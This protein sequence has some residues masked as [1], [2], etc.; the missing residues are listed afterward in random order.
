MFTEIFYYIAK[1]QIID[2]TQ[3]NFC[4]IVD[5]P[6]FTKY[7]LNSL[8]LFGV[9]FIPDEVISEENKTPAQF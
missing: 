2:L 1:T 5:Y 8:K 9:I 6:G 4:L 7:S 3:N